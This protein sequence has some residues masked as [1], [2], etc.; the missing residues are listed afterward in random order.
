MKV[1]V[2]AGIVAAGMLGGALILSFG[3]HSAAPLGQETQR[4][5]V[6]EWSFTAT[7]E[8]RIV[9]ASSQDGITYELIDTPGAVLIVPQGEDVIRVVSK[10]SLL[11]FHAWPTSLATQQSARQP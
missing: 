11:S 10:H 6:T 3:L 9:E 7:G 5:S 2:A 4:F 8:N 1:I